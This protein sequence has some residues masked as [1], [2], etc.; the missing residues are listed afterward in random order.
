MSIAFPEYIVKKLDNETQDEPLPDGNQAKRLK[1]NPTQS[2]EENKAHD[3]AGIQ[4]RGQSRANLSTL[5][6]KSSV[7]EREESK[8]M[9]S[10][11]SIAE[12]TDY[13]LKKYPSKKREEENKI[14][15][16]GK[17]KKIQAATLKKNQAAIKP[18][19]LAVKAANATTI[20]KNGRGGSTSIVARGRGGNITASRGRGRGR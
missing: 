2:N 17:A 20:A 18:E 11:K 12:H 3:K 5:K 1:K 4:T 10:K 16:D 13:I 19:A 14:A 6:L 9:L 8:A 7:E 15:E